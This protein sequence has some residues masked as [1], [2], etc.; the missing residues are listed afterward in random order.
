MNVDVG[1][2]KAVTT[3]K[4]V[5][6]VVRLH[7]LDGLRGTLALFVCAYHLT[8]S[9]PALKSFLGASTAVMQQGWFAVD[10]FFAL[11]GFVMCYVY[12]RD[13]R[14]GVTWRQWARFMWAR[15]SRLYPVHLVTLAILFVLL[16]PFILDTDRF[17][18]AGGRYS[19]QAAIGNLLMLQGPWIDHRTWNYPSWSISVEWH[20]YLIFPFLLPLIYRKQACWA[21]VVGGTVMAFL[22]YGYLVSLGLVVDN[23]ELEVFPTNGPIALLR[24]LLLFVVG[25]GLYGVIRESLMASGA[26]MVSA[27]VGLLACLHF[28]GLAPVAVLFVPILVLGAINNHAARNVLSLPPALFLGKISYSLYMCHALVQIMVVNRIRDY[29]TALLGD[30]VLAGGL[31]LALGIALSVALATLAQSFVETP[32]RLYLKNFGR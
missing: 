9:L 24:G 27:V 18:N 21:L 11:S 29:V 16:V 25:I 28:D 5:V 17:I 14:D 3:R 7:S 15:F 26:A 20:L 19:W 30:A 8:N 10:V 13:F 32:C 31:V 12:E 22:V 2:V 4:P 1:Y 23:G 6:S